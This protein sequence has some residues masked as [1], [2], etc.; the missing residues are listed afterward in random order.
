MSERK[1]G[2]VDVRKLEAAQ[3]KER[4]RVPS[5]TVRI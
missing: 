3:A 4:A 5:G 1:C 2:I